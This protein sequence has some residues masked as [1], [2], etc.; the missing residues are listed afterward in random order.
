M[1]KPTLANLMVSHLTSGRL[2]VSFQTMPQRLFAIIGFV[3]VAVFFASH[4]VSA[5]RPGAVSDA[6]IVKE[7]T[8]VASGERVELFQHGVEVDP[9]F[10]RLAE[11]AY[12]RL[13]ALTGRTFDTTTVG[14][15]IRMYVSRGVTISHVWKGYDHPRDPRGIVFLNAR[16]YRA[17]LRGTNATYVHEMSHL[18]TWRYQSHTLR[19]GLADF[20]ALQVHPGADVGPNV[21]GYDLSSKT[22]SDI[23]VYLG[24]TNLPPSWLIS[25]APRRRAY[26]SASYRFV[27]F[28]IEKR[29]MST[30]LKLYDAE[31]PEMELPKL[32]GANREEVVR[33]AGM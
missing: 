22:P 31:N 3:Y 7:A 6:D 17:G 11:Q 32:Y 15:K 4:P 14:P 23:V 29:G 16:V 9:A 18:L 26:Y 25:D 33:M 1:Q 2:Y 20:L 10:L 12:H 27:K 30:F 24:T 5:Q 28:L 13:E 8:L 21:G 19:E